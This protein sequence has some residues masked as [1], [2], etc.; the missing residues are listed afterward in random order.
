MKIIKSLLPAL[1]L[2]TIGG[3]RH[4]TDFEAYPQV[5]YMNDVNP[6]LSG[7]CT[8]S[9]CHD[10]NS[11]FGLSAYSDVVRDDIV[12]PSDP[13]KSQLYRL[14]KSLGGDRMPQPPQVR[15]SD[16]QI[17]TIYLWIGQGAKNN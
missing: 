2:L 5:S 10:G 3:C 13:Q 9:G 11:Q 1:L 6:I 4:K 8:Q 7:N 17:K 12:V 16:Q 15:L 14:I